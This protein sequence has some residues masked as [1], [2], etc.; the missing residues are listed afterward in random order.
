MWHILPAMSMTA[1]PNSLV[2][3][4]C[5]S[6]DTPVEELAFGWFFRWQF[7]WFQWETP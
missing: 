5:A 2:Q 7:E 6:S 4:L 3:R 1:E